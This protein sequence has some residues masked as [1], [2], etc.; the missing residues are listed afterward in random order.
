MQ[1]LRV[2]LSYWYYKDTDLDAIFAKFF[3]GNYPDVFADSGAFSAMTQG[4]KVD[5]NAYAAWLKRYKH[6]FS[7][8]ANLDVIGDPV[9]TLENQIK[10]E[11]LGLNPIPVFHAS[12]DYQPL[13]HYLEMGYKYIALGGLVQYCNQTKI[14]M[15]FLIKAFQ[16][17][18]NKAVFHGFGLTTWEIIASFPWYSVDSSSWGAGF[19]YGIVPIFDPRNGGFKKAKLGDYLS[20][21]KVSKL[22]VDMGF[23]PLDFADRSRNKRANICAISALSYIKAESYL[24][25]KF[26]EIYIPG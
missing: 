1:K 11:N 22:I 17:V 5:L 15:R 3:G 21:Q 2:L 24:R 7:T 12:S 23:D 20:L 4:G 8:Y 16:L 9:K 25:K 19:R 14:R 6:L 26:G 18:K 10:L 13:L